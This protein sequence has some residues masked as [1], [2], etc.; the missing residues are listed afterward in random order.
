M[1]SVRD[2]HYEHEISW[3]DCPARAVRFNYNGEYILTCGSDKTLKLINPYKNTLLK[4]YI[5]HG[6]EVLDCEA[7][8]DSGKLV[9]CSSDRTVNYWDVSTGKVVRKFRGHLSV[10][11]KYCF[12][13]P[14]F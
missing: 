2:L 6:Y 8:A 9:S 3:Q 13:N 14:S 11:Y 5:G 1:V 7:S 10:R 12:F 4:T